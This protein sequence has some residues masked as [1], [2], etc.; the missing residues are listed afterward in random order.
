LFIRSQVFP[1]VEIDP[2]IHVLSDEKWLNFILS[3]LVTN[4][5]KY[6]AGKGRNVFI[7]AR[8]EW[9]YIQMEVKDEGIGI[10]T[11]DLARIFDPYFTGDN[12]RQFPA[13]TGMGL[14]LVHEI[15]D[16]LGHHV[17]AESE[18]HAGTTLRLKFIPMAEDDQY[19]REEP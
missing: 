3:Q 14:Y 2:R 8:E 13:A 9:D 7:S 11:H 6:S 15:C 1:K 18:L 17:E 10:P 5:V 4:A 12:G 19:R 16:R